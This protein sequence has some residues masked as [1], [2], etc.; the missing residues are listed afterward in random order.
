MLI[1]RL[2]RLIRFLAIF[3]LSAIITLIGCQSNL[4]NSTSKGNIASKDIIASDHSSASST[5]KS[6]VADL[7][8]RPEAN[9]FSFEN[10]GNE[11]G[12]QNLTP[13]DMRRMFGNQVCATTGDTCI[14]TPPAE[15]WMEETNKGMNG[16]H[17]EGMAALSLILYADQAKAKEFGNTPDL[18]LQ[19]NEKLQREIAYWF[20]TQGVA[21]TA[22]NEIKDKT[23]AEILDI[24]LSSIKPNESID[25]TYTMGIY[26]PDF[27]GGHAITPY[28][29]EDMGDGKYIVMIYDNNH[30][31]L[32]RQVEIDRKANTWKY[33]ASTKPGEAESEY[34]GNAE[35]KTLT[36]TPTQPRYKIQECSFCGNAEVSNDNASEKSDQG[37]KESTTTKVQFN[38]IFL[39]GDADLLISNGN[40]KLG[41]ENGKFVDSFAGATF[42][43]MKSSELW[44][45]DEEP[46]YNIPVG[47]PFTMTLQS[48]SE[49]NGKELTDL[50]MIGPGYDLGLE[51]IKVLAGQKDLIKFDASGRSLSYKPSSS[52]A[53][54]IIFGLSTAND[55]YEFELDGVEIDAGGTISSN[56]DTAKGRL[57]IKIADSKQEASFNLILTRIDEKTEQTFEGENLTLDSGDTL[58]LD[59]AK[60]TGNGA[61]LT[62]ELDKGSDGVIDETTTLD[63]KKK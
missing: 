12:I 51:G 55:D 20:A 40:Q 33:V 56:L 2:Q 22:T 57:V 45:D 25:K 41:Y 8:F 27:K 38:Q 47:V 58:Y 36:L 35:T 48:S 7:G 59:Y 13:V 62:I 5:T 60:W 16:G 23:P 63:D 24:L 32:E 28:A 42:I 37:N 9:G 53:P 17:C 29:I 31:K 10:Y 1:K 43:P 34:A 54:N 3:S 46:L 14:L 50:V 61:K 18:S 11:G 21:P 4:A 26:Q 6:L 15:Q 44:K 19:G 49:T 52:E 30:P 39:E